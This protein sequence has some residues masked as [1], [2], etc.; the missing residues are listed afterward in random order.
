M[1]KDELLT[2]LDEHAKRV[3]DHCAG[4]AEE[5]ITLS[6]LMLKGGAEIVDQTAMEVYLMSLLEVAASTMVLPRLFGMV[7]RSVKEPEVA[8]AEAETDKSEEGRA[9][10]CDH[11]NE[12]PLLCPCDAGCYCKSHTCKRRT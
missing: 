6:N 2:E 4:L 11:A 12:V 5:G 3:R 10:M 7:K 9:M 8:K 1:T